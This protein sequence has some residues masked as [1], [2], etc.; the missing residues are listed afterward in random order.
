MKV[1]VHQSHR[2]IPGCQSVWLMQHKARLDSPTSTPT[3]SAQ[4]AEV[5]V[6]S[7]IRFWNSMQRNRRSHLAERK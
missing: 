3:I 2:T 4:V 7:Q 6:G 1:W 5:V